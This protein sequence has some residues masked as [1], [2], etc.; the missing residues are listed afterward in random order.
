MTRSKKLLYSSISGVIYQL[1]VI[2]CGFILPRYIIKN[3]GSSVYGLISS[4]NQF[5]NFVMLLE[6]GM[7]AVV[8]S[9]L[10]RPLDKHD[11][12]EISRIYVSSNRFFTRIGFVFCI[13]IIFI[14]IF[15]PLFFQ[16]E[17]DFFY[18][19]SLIIILS[20]TAIAE[21]MVGISY[22]IILK[23]DQMNGVLNILRSI[24]L[25]CSTIIA[26]VLIKMD[27]GIHIVK[28]F[29]IVPFVIRPFIIKEYAT[30]KYQ[31]NRKIEFS[32]EPIKQKWNG[33]AQH[34]AFYITTSTD[35]V[36]LTVFSTL[37]NISIY[38]VYTLVLNGV[39]G[40]VNSIT[41]GI[42]A[43]FGNA[44][45]SSNNKKSK[46][47]FSLIEWFSHSLISFIYTCTGIL[48]LPFIS[49]YTKGITDVDYY[50]P[51]FAFIATLSYALRSIRDPYHSAVI[52]AGHFKETQISSIVESIINISLSIVGVYRFGLNGVIFGTLIAMLY[53]IIYLAVYVS[54]NIV[55]TEISSFIKN[56]IVDIFI[57]IFGT[58]LCN[59]Y[60]MGGLT[61]LDWII[62]SIKVSLSVALLSIII[63]SIVN[64]R[65]VVEFISKLKRIY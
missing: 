11:Y 13:Y 14:S 57:A 52:G 23:A 51:F 45:I 34:I 7:N 22:S 30:K 54:N 28:L 42:P 40:L 44:F 33:I 6:M 65:I 21:Y 17:F 16:N 24:S 55:M 31:I 49:V 5:L 48:I 41:S 26:L 56:I 8:T 2:V 9:S 64:K 36:V 19:F 63:N 32:G 39:L 50:K 20:V 38:G 60:H 10:Y 58:F 53:R 4:I 46:E 29:S 3:Y 43:F 18:V 1:T 12:D 35:I 37:G 62:Y 47:I 61:Y 25:I 27:F 59:C 15:Y